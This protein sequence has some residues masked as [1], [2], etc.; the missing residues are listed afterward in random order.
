MAE[1]V[2]IISNESNRGAQLNSALVISSVKLDITNY[3]A[4]SEACLLSI[5]ANRTQ[6][7]INGNSKLPE[8]TNPKFDDWVSDNAMVKTWLYNSINA[9]NTG[10]SKPQNKQKWK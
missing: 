2:K 8:K 3:L 9:M 4:W 1:E 10:T 5:Q 7:F 6:R